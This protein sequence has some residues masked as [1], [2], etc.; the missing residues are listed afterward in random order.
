MRVL[1]VGELVD[2]LAKSFKASSETGNME[3]DQIVFTKIVR[4]EATGL[5]V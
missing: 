2:G 4:D 3:P 1:P 5:T